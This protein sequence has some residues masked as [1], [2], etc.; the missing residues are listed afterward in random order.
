VA[1]DLVWTVEARDDR[2]ELILHVAQDSV[3]NAIALDD[4]V[5]ESVEILAAFP[6]AG[7]TGRVIGTRELVV[8]RSPYLVVYEVQRGR[9]LVLRLLHMAQ[10]WPPAAP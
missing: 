4:R 8:P 2:R 10:Q 7:R 1:V 3:I 9:I 6:E 5:E